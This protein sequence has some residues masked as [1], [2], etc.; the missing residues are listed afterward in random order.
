MTEETQEYK[1]E[2]GKET[3]LKKTKAVKSIIPK[4]LDNYSTQV[5][6]NANIKVCS[7]CGEK[8]RTD[9]N[10]NVFCPQKNPDCPITTT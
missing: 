1:V 6:V 9:Q 10:G 5:Y 4:I 2:E 8:R 3:P 7:I